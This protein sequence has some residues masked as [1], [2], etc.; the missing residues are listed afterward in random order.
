[1]PTMSVCVKFNFAKQCTGLSRD[2]PP[3][4]LRNSEFPRWAPF[5]GDP[6]AETGLFFELRTWWYF[7]PHLPL[8][9]TLCRCD[10]GFWLSLDVWTSFGRYLKQGCLEC[11]FSFPPLKALLID[12]CLTN[13]VCN[14]CSSS[15]SPNEDLSPTKLLK[16]IC[17]LLFVLQCS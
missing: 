4:F 12:I 17:V 7:F 2:H 15:C 13:N 16:F 10:W 3:A 9:A 8:L 11:Y 14:V 6:L 5:F 1:M